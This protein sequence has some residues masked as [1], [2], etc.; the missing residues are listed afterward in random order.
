MAYPKDFFI[1]YN[2]ADR[3]W[4]EWIAWVLESEGYT[5]V[6][7]DWDFKPGGNFVVEMDNA[8]KQCERTLAVLS[9][10]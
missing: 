8:A 9:Q 2:K 1:S 7:Q 3:P 4:A 5:T 10:D 6:V